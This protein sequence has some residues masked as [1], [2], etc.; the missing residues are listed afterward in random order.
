MLNTVFWLTVG[1]LFSLIVGRIFRS[2]RMFWIAIL[3]VLAGFMCG[4]IAENESGKSEK[5]SVV[6]ESTPM[7]LSTCSL[8]AIYSTIEYDDTRT[9][10]VKAAGKDYRTFNLN[11]NCTYSHK[12]YANPLLNYHD[13]FDTS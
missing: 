10:F 7:Q 12:T 13:Y 2:N 8:Q 5:V 9:F 4:T 6:D 3:C 11:N 1:V